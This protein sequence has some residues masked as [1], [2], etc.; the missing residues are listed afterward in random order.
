MHQAKKLP[1]PGANTIE[2][3]TDEEASDSDNS[4][5][6]NLTSPE[7]VLMLIIAVLFDTIGLLGFIPD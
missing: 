7:G 2:E 1:P 4:A 6:G 3:E 5:A